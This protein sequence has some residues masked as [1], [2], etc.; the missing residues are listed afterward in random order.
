MAILCNVAGHV[1]YGTVEGTGAAIS[2]TLGFAPKYVQINN[3]DGNCFGFWYKGL[4]DGDAQ[5]VVDSGVGTTDVSL[6]TSNGITDT[7][8]GFTIGTD[9]NL[10]ANGETLFWLAIGE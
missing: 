4:G 1:A 7:A 6:I 10:N 3:V 9:T 5:K 8:T 2:V